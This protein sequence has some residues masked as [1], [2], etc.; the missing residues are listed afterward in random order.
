MMLSVVVLAHNSQK[1]LPACLASVFGQPGGSWEVIL[2]DNA[3]SDG[4]REIVQKQYPQTRLIENPRNFGASRAR[5]Q[6]IESSSGD[7]I[8]FLDSDVVLGNDFLEKFETIRRELPGHVGM[9]QPNILTADG[10]TIYSQGIHL[11]WLRR[12]FDLNHGK[13]GNYAGGGKSRI[14]GPCSAA[15]FY[16]RSLLE[17]LKEK[18]GYFDERFFFLVE[19]VDLAWRAQRAG[20]KV[21]FCPSMVCL[22]AG[23]SSR[24]DKKFRQYLCFRNR[25]WMIEK[26]EGLWGRMRVYVL[27]APYEIVRWIYLAIF[28]KYFWMKP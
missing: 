28:N 13:P 21:L 14:I 11:T 20:G 4:T 7:W 22:H 17:R 3:S 15:A 10:K 24:T 18:T 23:N 26:N 8:L 19:D 16:R 6:G 27:S 2:V 5:N 9:I 1:H 12:F 25:Y